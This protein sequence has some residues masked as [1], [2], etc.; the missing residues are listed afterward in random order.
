MLDLRGQQLEDDEREILRHPLVGGVILFSRNYQDPGQITN[1]CAEIHN[2]RS[3][4]LLIAVD[5]EGGRV[6]R[7]HKHFTALPPCRCYGEQYDSNAEKGMYLS[8]RGGWV[9][10]AELLAVGVDFSFAPVLDLDR[11]VSAVIGNRAFHHHE[12]TAALLAKSFMRGMKLAGMASVGKHFPG[13]GSVIQD[14]HIETPVDERRYED[15]AMGDMLPFER[16]VHAGLPAVMPAHVIYPKVDDRPAGYSHTWLQQVLRQRLGFQGVIFSD[17]ISMEGAGIAGDY[18]DR[19][20]AALDAGCDMVLICNNQPAAVK[21]LEQMDANPH[22]ASQ[23]RLMRMHG[24]GPDLS[25][26]DL[27]SSDRWKSTAPM[28]AGLDRLPELELGDD[29]IK[30]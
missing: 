17:D 8:E 26:A 30:S 2:L 24:H 10:A 6:Q 27:Q 1:L 18:I 20:R 16:L 21:V 28:I 15:I 4:P 11:G 25:L 5:H 14:S 12:E 23:A 29:E 22:P 9:M 13:H 7:F 3:P 19:V